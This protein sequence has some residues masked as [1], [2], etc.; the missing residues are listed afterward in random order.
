MEAQIPQDWRQVQLRSTCEPTSI[1]NP[2][3]EPRDEFWYVD[4]SAVS[5]ENLTIQSPQRVKGAQAPSRA[6]KIVRTGDVIFATVRPTLRRIAFVGDQFDNQIASTA[7]CVIRA[8]R[9]EADPRFLYYAVQTDAFNEGVATF[10]SGASYPAVNDKDVLNGHINLPPKT[11]QEKIAAALRKV[12]RA[13]ESEQKLTVTT[14]ELKRST[15]RQL[16]T[17]G[18]RASPVAET[19][20]YPFPATWLRK[21]L[22]DVAE[23]TYGAQAAVADALDPTI[24][25]PILTNINITN[26]GRIDVTK[27]RYYKVPEHQLERLSLAKGDVLFN[28]RSG[29]A[30]H[31]GKTALFELDGDFTYSSFILRFRV[32]AHVISTF[33]YYYLHYIKSQGF[34]T[35]RRNVSS[36]NSVYNASL[37]ATIPIYFPSDEA[38]QREISKI[39]QT[40]DRKISVHERKRAA[41]SDLFHILLHQMMT[42]EIRVDNLDIDASDVTTLNPSSA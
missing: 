2:I 27:L 20:V 16:F 25:T 37:S 11:Q 41:L 19:E 26:E 14:R 22:A 8:N 31:I 18:L 34:F 13:I 32:R 15:I 4:V 38:E 42:A 36:I 7:F 9:Q 23:I 12:Q 30:D 29:S 33:L 28:W 10:Q 5:R 39:L 24:G 3:R 21:P 40:L 1:W 35:A 17:Y 6:R